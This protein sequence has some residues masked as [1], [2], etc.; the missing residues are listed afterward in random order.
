MA[1]P[2][3]KQHWERVYEEKKPDEVSW[4]QIRPE[5][6][7]D[8]IGRACLPK[9]GRVIDVGGGAS[10]LVDYLLDG[11]FTDLTVL[12]I[13]GSALHHARTRLGPRASLVSWVEADVT[14]T[15][16]AGPYDLWHDR[17]VFHFLTDPDDRARY[18][19]ALRRHL[20]PGGHLIL[21]AFAPDGPEKCSGLPVRRYD[22]DLLKDELGRDFSL[23]KEVPET[24]RTPWGDE[25]RFRYYLWSRI[26]T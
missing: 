21:A 10:V 18:L 13:A 15:E 17:A 12:D 19:A 26:L 1:E 16:P 14:R 11:G 22:A 23:L 25:Q 4:Y 6:S 9:I 24:H 5:V 7:L 2:D 20:R 8:L 3:R